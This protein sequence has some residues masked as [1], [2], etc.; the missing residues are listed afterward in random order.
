MARR[1][2]RAWI[3]DMARQR[4]ERLFE[5]AEQEFAE[6]PER[7]NRYVELARRISMRNRVRIPPYLKRRMCRECYSYLVPGANARTRLHGRG[8]YIV[9]TCLECGHQMRRPY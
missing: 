8:R 2:R 7:S 4:I 6:H 5:L 1:R 3:R 9:T